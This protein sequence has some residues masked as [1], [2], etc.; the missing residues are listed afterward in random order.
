MVIIEW[1]DN[2]DW[3]PKVMYVMDDPLGEY[4]LFLSI[5]KEGAKEFH[6]EA[7]AKKFM[8]DIYDKNDSCTMED[9]CKK[10]RIC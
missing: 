2:R 4:R 6:D 9:F 1:Y 3:Q 8:T 7:S 5:H 10:Y